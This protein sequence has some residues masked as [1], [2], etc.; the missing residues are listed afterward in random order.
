MFVHIGGTG[1]SILL[2]MGN[3]SKQF[4][5]VADV[6]FSE[7]LNIAPLLV[8]SNLEIVLADI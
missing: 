7:V 5:L 1:Y 8:L 6:E 2:A 4:V 3:D